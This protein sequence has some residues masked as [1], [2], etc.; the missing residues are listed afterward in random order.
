MT[1]Q[2]YD[3]FE[4]TFPLD[5]STTTE[6]LPMPGTQ[7][8]GDGP[9]GDAPGDPAEAPAPTRAKARSRTSPISGRDRRS[10]RR[11]WYSWVSPFWRSPSSS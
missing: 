1:D 2:S 9:A 8:A 10:G 7:P 3:P 11:W 6:R 4:R 5:T